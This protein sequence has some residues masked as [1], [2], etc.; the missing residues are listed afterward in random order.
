MVVLGKATGNTKLV[1]QVDG[2]SS[3]FKN[4]STITVQKA[5]I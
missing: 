2:V 4:G 3:K 1:P 5:I